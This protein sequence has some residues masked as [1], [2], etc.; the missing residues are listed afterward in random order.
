V[1]NATFNNIS[2]ISWRSDLLV[3][4]TVF[5][6]WLFYSHSAIVCNVVIRLVPDS[7]H[8]YTYVLI[9]YMS[10]IKCNVWYYYMNTQQPLQTKIIAEKHL[11][12]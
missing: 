11:G 2:V 10:I 3:E 6:R 1:F 9:I 8:E 5:E 12:H 4:E 7:V